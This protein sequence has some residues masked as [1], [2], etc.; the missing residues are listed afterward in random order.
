MITSVSATL[1][2]PMQTVYAATKAAL[3]SI[4]RV[5]ATELGQKYG[6]TIN[7]ISPGPVKTDMFDECEPDVTAALQRMIDV[8]PAAPRAGEVSDIV[9]IVS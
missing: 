2:M 5:W 4:C 7:A 3:E 9:P 8:T 1:G 6:I